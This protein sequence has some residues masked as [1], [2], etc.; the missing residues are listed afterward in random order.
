[1]LTRTPPRPSAITTSRGLVG[2]TASL[3]RSGSYG[4]TVGK[5]VNRFQGLTPV[6]RS[7]VIH[8]GSVGGSFRW[9]RRTVS[10]VGAG[11]GPENRVSLRPERCKNR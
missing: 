6:G 9:R 10:R 2:E 4:F 3:A 11:P 1:M 8:P 7:V 5:C